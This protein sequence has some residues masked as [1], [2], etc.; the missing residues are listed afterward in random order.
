[1]AVALLALPLAPSSAN[2]PQNEHGAHEIPAWVKNRVELQ[3]GDRSGEEHK[4]SHPRV[5]QDS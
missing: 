4:S 1:V 2:R 5:G 3:L